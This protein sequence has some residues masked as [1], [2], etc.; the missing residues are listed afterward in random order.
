MPRR[1]DNP[2]I[3]RRI[4]NI[5]GGP[6]QDQDSPFV[7]AGRRFNLS[8]TGVQPVNSSA[9]TQP[10]AEENP[11]LSYM[12]RM[13]GGGKATGAY[14]EHIGN[15]PTPEAYAPSKMRRLGGA[16]VA[17]AAS[18]N[19]PKRGAELGRDIID[20]PYKNALDSWSMKGAG[21]KEQA[22]IEQDDATSQL[23]YMKAVRQAQVDKETQELNRRKVDIDQEQAN[24]N[25]IYREA[26]IEDMENNDWI[27]DTD[28]L[29]NTVLYHPDGRVKNMG[30][31]MAGR[32]Q[33][34][35][36]RGTA[37]QGMNAQT[38]R[39]QANTG[40]GNLN[41]RQAEFGY[42]QGQDAIQNQFDERRVANS[43]YGTDITA[44]NAGAAGFVNAGEN[45]T[46]NAMAAQEVARTDPKFAGWSLDEKG[47]PRGPGDWFGTNA[48][49]QTAREYL[50]AIEKA[51]ATIIGNR[52]PGVGTVPSRRVTA[53]NLGGGGM[54]GP[55]NFNDLK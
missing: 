41:Q 20:A 15:M 54:G 25:R 18:F 33:A 37:Y 6:G 40:I 3:S 10:D 26:Q 24:T 48:P 23:N 47:M 44:A 1:E 46:A 39:I 29:G 11:L 43:E 27:K 4:S 35:R 19:D 16:L 30:P 9:V 53:P 31:S 45:F 51:K 2:F 22:N 32:Q 13:Q 36:E 14:R 55:L 52:R 34:D 12:Q 28:A 50:A 49:D 7:N 38:N 42:R 8:P 5:F 17:G 21:L